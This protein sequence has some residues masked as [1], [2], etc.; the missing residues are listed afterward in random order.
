M[1]RPDARVEAFLSNKKPDLF[2]SVEH[3]HQIWREDPYDVESVHVEARALF[4]R[5]LAQATTPPGLE[6]GRLL[7]LLGDAGSG[8]THLL[9]AFRNHVHVN[10]HGFVGYLQM[11]TAIRSYSRYLASNLV[12]SLDQAY[13]EPLG[14][15]SGL[16][17]L[18]RAIAAKCDDKE[19]LQALR[20]NESLEHAAVIELVD[21]AAERIITHPHCAEL[22]L[23]LL[24]AL[25]L[26]QRQDPVLRSRTV[27]Y[28]RCEELPER[29]RQLLGGLSRRDS[30][31]GAQR[32]IEQ[33]GRL[34]WAC[35]NRV[36][37][38]CV[39]QFEDAH[40]GGVDAEASFR[41]VMSTLCAIADQVPSSIVVIACLDE[42]YDRL[43][44]RLTRSTLDRIES[45]PASVRLVAE[46]K[47]EEVE[48]IIQQRLGYLYEIS[49]ITPDEQEDDPVYPVPRDFVQRLSGLRIRDVLDECRS[50]RERCMA[51]GRIVAPSGETA[52]PPKKSNPTKGTKEKPRKATIDQAWNDYLA[53]FTDDP[54]DADAAIAELV[55]WA[56]ETAADELESGHRFGVE[57]KGSTIEVRIM[58]PTASGTYRVGEEILIVVCNKGPRGGGLRGQAEAAVKQAGH[59][60]PVLL[61]CGEFPNNQGTAVSKVLAKITENGGRKAVLES[62]DLRKLAAFRRFYDEH[63]TREQF[64][65]WLKEQTHLSSLLPLVQA[66]DLDH[67]ERFEQEG[68]SR[69]APQQPPADDRPSMFDE[70]PKSA[71]ADT[72][73]TESTPPENPEGP[74]LVRTGPVLLGTTG[75]LVP[76]DLTIDGETLTAH[77]A[78]L[79]ST[80]SGKTTL[81]L[82]VIE[83]LL[84]QNVPAILVDRKGDL[85]AYA[86]EALFHDPHEDPA[87]DARRQALRERI[88]VAVFT[89]GHPEGRQLAL[90]LL[91]RGF[92]GLDDLERDQAAGY[93]AHALGDML[94]YKHARKDKALRAI[95]VQ[96]FR[97]FAVHGISEKFDLEALITLIANEDP[98]LVGTI[99]R[100]DTKIFKD[101]VHDLQV[102]QLGTANLLFSTG[103]QLDANL[104]LGL[105]PHARPGRTRL[106]IVSTK[107]L[108]DNTQILFWVSQLLLTL[109]RWVTRAPSPHLQ[110]VVLFDEADVYL[111]A[112]GQPATKAPMENLLRRA[113]S[114]GLGLM[115]ATQSPGDLDYKCRDNI[116]SWFLGRVTQ[117]VALEK[118]RPLL[119]EAR[120]NVTARIPNQGTGEFHLLKD[121]AVTPFKGHLSLL[122][123]E[124]VPE[125]EILKIAARHKKG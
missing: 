103:E 1:T 99:G 74:S 76:G 69:A 79:G 45:D 93:A 15:E 23:D 37:V 13:Y 2:H 39:D 6:A 9:R 46:R 70:L 3:R 88:D 38:I 90:S 116:R 64:K 111:P 40:Y 26:L 11:M 54:P 66:L 51:A 25:L 73:K 108:G 104:L 24:R 119:S 117:T 34:M 102:L 95:L 36:L 43:R 28:L 19:A 17:K 78:Y 52:P 107:F 86:R 114:G 110:A 47:A 97:L 63:R 32:L 85:C 29:D 8:K 14:T 83:Q 101:L 113:R 124:Q 81:A 56:L 94:G 84:L 10:G 112:V 4:K 22:D 55:A 33:L 16:L 71:G 57:V 42:Y 123:T 109:T 92:A 118:M 12:A 35:H 82:N 122:R 31:E 30:E 75:E 105:G 98:A 61:R 91:P 21:R 100:L 96:A 48:Q 60:I 77:A 18:S 44:G 89:P 50:F 20:E 62:T 80:G 59:R 5:M 125:A 115:L 72:P 120:V 41:R 65:E 106:S 27:K 58:V 67:L 49:R 53:Q 87:L 68:E 7:L 121:G